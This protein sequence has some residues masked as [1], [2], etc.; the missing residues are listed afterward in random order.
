MRYIPVFILLLTI[1]IFS[2]EW[3]VGSDFPLE[4]LEDQNGILYTIPKDTKKVFFLSD[5]EAS[6]ILHTFMAPKDPDYLIEKKAVIISDIHKMPGLITKFVALPKMQ[7]YNYRIL[8]IRDNET[9]TP[10]PKEKNSI[11]LL[12]IKKN[13]ITEIRFIKNLEDLEKAFEEK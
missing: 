2:E 9:G 13:K 4:E 5:M 6:K 10:F 1:P 11:T 3:Q 12:R 8:L 7:S